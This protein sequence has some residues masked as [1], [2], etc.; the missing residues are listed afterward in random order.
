MRILFYLHQYPAFGGIERVT[1][2]LAKR[3]ADD[4]HEVLI[5]SL[6]HGEGTRLLDDLPARAR[7]RPLP[8]DVI[9][10]PRNRKAFRSTLDEF[11]P[12]VII[13]QDSYSDIEFLLF[14]VVRDWVDGLDT[15]L[16]SR[17]PS[18]PRPLDRPHRLDPGA[19]LFLKAKEAIRSAF[20]PFL[21]TVRARHESARRR[22]ICGAVDAYVVLSPRYLPL[23][24][25]LVGTR[26]AGKLRAI[27]NPVQA[28]GFGAG[29]E[30]RRKEVL[31]L[32][33]LNA[34]TKGCDRILEV[35]ARLERD[36]P[37]WSFRVVGDGV[38]RK[39]LE[40]RAETLSLRHVVF[41]GFQADTALFFRQASLFV[42]ASDYEGWPMVLGES[43]QAGCVPVVT[44]SFEAAFDIV[45]DGVS[46]R[47][48]RHF[49]VRAYEGALRGLM[50]DGERRAAFARA[51]MRKASSFS[52]DAVAARWY[53]LF[54][55]LASSR[56]SSP[57]VV[58]TVEHNRPA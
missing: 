35:W 13:F 28:D 7:W 1:T 6:R 23:V 32:G 15:R 10:S 31:F 14:D 17:H 55:E 5:V 58:I 47:V 39:G 40:R 18:F 52:V 33:T 53:A 54:G 45:E 3:F 20:W 34:K 44:D 12:E 27:P 49:D 51:A 29:S 57:P 30:T 43:M 19:S 25:R 24:R 42:M 37:D 11:N 16:T 4:G 48:V 2:I 50:V 56:G 36:F 9:D 22:Y 8:E 26:L 41:S 46:G 21:K 38:E